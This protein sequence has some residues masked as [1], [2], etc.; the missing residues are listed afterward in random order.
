MSSKKKRR[1][2]RKMGRWILGIGCMLISAGAFAA[3]IYF[4]NAGRDDA[5]AESEQKPE[6]KTEE[7]KQ[8]ESNEEESAVEKKLE[9]MTLEDKIAQMFMITPDALTGVEGTWNPGEVTENAFKERPVGGLIMSENNLASTEQVQVWNDTLTGFS[10]ETVGVDIFLAVEEEG[11]VSSMIAENPVFEVENVDNMSE[12]GNLGNAQEAYNAGRT[13]G[14][15]LN[16]LGFNMNLAPLADVWTNAENT[17]EKYRAFGSEPELVSDMVSEAVKGFR[18]Q[19]ICTVAKYFPGQGG[20]DEENLSLDC[21]EEELKE[22]EFLP[23]QSAIEA[24]TEAI[25]V[26]HCTL[27]NILEDDTPA[28]LSEEVIEEMLRSELGFGG[29]VITDALD[30]EIITDKYSSSEAAVQ[31]IQAGADI[32]LMPEDFEDAY[33]GILSAVKSGTITEERI[34][35]SVKRIL[36]VKIEESGEKAS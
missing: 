15:Y 16:E 29:I 3:V 25:M 13:I 14:T 32:L 31:A 23:F 2:R 10:K 8:Q 9:E 24:G 21:T 22:C 36:E 7:K 12:I 6:E 4:S 20:T 17:S 26:G 28:S 30:Q 1:R 33:Q 18:S 34:D 35:E 11:G 5:G 19:E 27:P